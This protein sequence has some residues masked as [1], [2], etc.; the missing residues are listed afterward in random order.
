MKKTKQE[1]LEKKAE[2][3]KKERKELN[4]LK[5]HYIPRYEL[6]RQRENQLK[7]IAMKGGKD[8]CDYFNVLVVK[9][10]NAIHDYQM[11]NPVQK[12]E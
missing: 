9:L 11:N 8:R 10:F 3:E 5:G 4:K 6:D 12:D 7:S 1:Y 2:K